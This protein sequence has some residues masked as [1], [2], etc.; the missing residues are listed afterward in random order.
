MAPSQKYRGLYDRYGSI[1]GLSTPL[2]NKYLSLRE[3]V[4]P[5][6]RGPVLEVGCGQGELLGLCGEV[7]IDARGCDIS[8]EMVA[9]CR[10]RGL[11]VDQV[12]DTLAYLKAAEPWDTLVLVDV[13][14]HMTRDEA[15]DVA[16]IAR[17]R[18]KRMV[19]Q[20]PNMA[21][22]FASLNLYH[23]LTHEWAYT[24]ASINQLLR[25]AGFGHI[26]VLPVDHPP[27]GLQHVRK[28]LRRGF[29]AGLW[30]LLMIDQPNRSRILTP[31]LLAIAE[32]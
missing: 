14:E 8:P 20:V 21:S 10:S 31:N 6:L 17:S 15:L 9:A 4:L 11:P 13:L 1:G 30:W 24:E 12:E 18:G 22:P 32:P 3:N 27:V 26:R 23:D 19:V 28:L 16:R 7:G 5:H 25:L 2:R 29:Y